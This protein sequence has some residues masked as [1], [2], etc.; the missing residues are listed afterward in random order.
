MSLSLYLV[1]ASDCLD[2]QSIKQDCLMLSLAFPF[3]RLLVSVQQY[4]DGNH[5]VRD[6]FVDQLEYVSLSLY[7]V[8][9]SDCLD[10]Q[11]IKQ[12][13]LMLSLAFPF[14]RLVVICTTIL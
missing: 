6:W 14:D 8:V 11:S 10:C 1:V 13:C 2:C 5:S 7:L 9:A 4:F 3:D 12:D